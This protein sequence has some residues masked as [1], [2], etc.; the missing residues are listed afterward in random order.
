MLPNIAGP[1]CRYYK[2]QKR[3]LATSSYK[4]ALSHDNWT[5]SMQILLTLTKEER[6]A[7]WCSDQGSNTKYLQD[8]NPNS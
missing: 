7:G 8:R 1:V 2:Y 4:L 5:I 6:K 3:Q